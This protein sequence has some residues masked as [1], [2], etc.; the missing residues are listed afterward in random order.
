MLY[1]QMF[2]IHTAIEKFANPPYESM[3]TVITQCQIISDRAA[4]T[5]NKR[6]CRSKVFIFIFVLF[7]VVQ[8]K[9]IA[10]IYKMNNINLFCVR[11]SK[12]A[13]CFLHAKGYNYQRH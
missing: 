11:I 6:C 2:E 7:L 5:K 4:Y 3:H 1:K 9:H 10:Q 13:V 8:I 12:N